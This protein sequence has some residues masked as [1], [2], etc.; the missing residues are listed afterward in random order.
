VAWV[1]MP[2]GMATAMASYRA[3][4]EALPHQR[5]DG[6]GSEPA[7]PTEGNGEGPE[8]AD[9]SEEEGPNVSAE[10][11]AGRNGGDDGNAEA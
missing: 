4:F 3:Q 9:H 8:M 5:D 10:A 11:G 6:N 7:L 2:M 1:L